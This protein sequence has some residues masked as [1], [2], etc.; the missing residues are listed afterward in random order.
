M[1]DPTSNAIN[2]ENANVEELARQLSETDHSLLNEI[3][4]GVP[5]TRLIEL[6][7]A[8]QPYENL[9]VNLC[10]WVIRKR[11]AA[12]ADL[13]GP[14]GVTSQKVVAALAV[15]FVSEE[16][17]EWAIHELTVDHLSDLINHAY[18]QGWRD[19]AIWF[20]Q[21][22]EARK[23]EQIRQLRDE[24]DVAINHPHP[25]N[26]ETS[27]EHIAADAERERLDYAELDAMDER[28]AIRKNYMAIDAGRINSETKPTSSFGLLG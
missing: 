25:P 22:A 14:L 17:R 13:W 27:P 5:D 2:P 18:H 3:L 8:A 4:N 16:D 23:I 20:G 9:H 28:N 10:A 1:S 11:Q 21:Q 6:L 26:F 19:L 24:L 15:D 12:V 7:K